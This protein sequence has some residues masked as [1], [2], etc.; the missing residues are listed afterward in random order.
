[1]DD[2]ERIL[3]ELK[4]LLAGLRAEVARLRRERDQMEAEAEAAHARIHELERERGAAPEK[5]V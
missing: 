2:D 1:M 4:A 5:P 3:S